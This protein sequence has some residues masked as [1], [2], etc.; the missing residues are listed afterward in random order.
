MFE[1]L[2]SVTFTESAERN[3]EAIDALIEAFEQKFHRICSVTVGVKADTGKAEIHFS[4]PPYDQQD[5]RENYPLTLD[6]IVAPLNKPIFPTAI[7]SHLQ[8]PMDELSERER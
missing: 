1:T 6:P 8:K 3:R 7:L 2:N 4:L 5:Q